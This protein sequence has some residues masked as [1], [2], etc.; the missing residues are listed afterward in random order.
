MDKKEIIDMAAES[1]LQ[2]IAIGDRG[3]IGLTPI[4]VVPQADFGLID[5]YG[6]MPHQLLDAVRSYNDR[7]G[8]NG[9]GYFDGVYAPAPQFSAD[10]LYVRCA[11]DQQAYTSDL[12][13]RQD[14]LGRAMRSGA[15]RILSD[16]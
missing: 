16:G 14:A 12:M 10:E 11:V 7:I 1:G 4:G 2:L 15:K 13:T 9:A 6:F 5:G 3:A 8:E